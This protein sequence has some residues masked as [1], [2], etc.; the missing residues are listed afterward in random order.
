MS[1][2]ILRAASFLLVFC[3][4]ASIFY[5]PLSAQAESPLSIP[6]DTLVEALYYEPADMLDPALSYDTSS[7][8]VIQ[9]VYET[10]ITYDREKM[11]QFI[12]Q[13]ADSWVISD[14]GL[15]YTFHIRSGV[16]FHDGSV[17]KPHDVAYSFQRGLLQG[18]SASPQWLLAEPFLGFGMTDITKIV[19]NGASMDNRDALKANDPAKLVAACQTVK[20]AIVADDIAGTVTMTL[21]QSWS[22]FLATL[23]GTFSSIL[24]QSWVQ[25]QG[26]WDGS[27]STWQDFYGMVKEEDPLTSI[28][29][30]TGPFKLNHWTV[31]SE[32]VLDRN[33]SYWRTTPMW[34]NGPSGQAGFNQVILRKVATAVDA[35]NM[36]VNGEADY[37][38]VTRENSAT[39]E[40][41]ILLRYNADGSVKSFGSTSGTLLAYENGLSAQGESLLF[42]YN[43]SAASPYIGSGIWT[44]GIPVN[45][46]SDIHVRKAFNYAFNWDQYINQ[47]YGG[48]AIQ[49]NGP[50]IKGVQGYADGQPHY[51]FDLTLAGSEMN[52]AFGGAAAA[53]GFTVTLV[54]NEGNTTRQMLCEILKNGIESLSPKYKVNIISLPWSDYLTQQRSGSLPVSVGGWIQDISHPH[55]WVVPYLTGVYA[56]RQYF[57]Q[58]IA[59]KYANLVNTCV[60]KIGDEARV[61]YEGIQ[62]S[63]YNDAIDIFLTQPLTITYLNA[64]VQGYYYNPAFFGPYLYSLS[65]GSIPSVNPV[66]PGSETTISFADDK[67]NSGSLTIPAGAVS[68]DIQI[69]I[70]PNIVVQPLGGDLRPSSLAFDIQG[71]RTS[72]NSAVN[73]TFTTPVPITL[74]YPNIP[75]IEDSLRLYYWNG[76]NWE[77]AACGGYVR[78]PAANTLTIPVCHFSQFELG[79]NTH[80]IF[81]PVTRR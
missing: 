21:A 76:T 46:F 69:V 2:R 80:P 57:P 28:M 5:S 37:A 50:I 13:L 79:G 17:L 44:N 30:G 14:D 77:D 70:H 41:N 7:G 19:D 22:P 36:L 75:L 20:A 16:K 29:N 74:S 63:T 55:N 62:T 8:Y 61:C 39:I 38:S 56:R 10:L 60:T 35:A 42:N 58:D 51:S 18:G 40:P 9:Q 31:G 1:K 33:A 34:P 78:N 65:R 54:Y 68:E 4:V 52:Q 24:S 3:M 45:F 59:D 66:T 81:L 6:N 32:L 71:Y 49:L 12:P 26:G 47:V 73:L 11:D 27:C 43:I 53:N 48:H 23:A 64:T 15:T 72:D 67:G 25:A